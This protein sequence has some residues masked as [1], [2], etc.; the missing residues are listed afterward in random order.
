M[1]C[2]GL[3]KEKSYF[4]SNIFS[5]NSIETSFTFNLIRKGSLGLAESYMRGEFETNN[6]SDLIELTEKNIKI[7]YKFSGLF[8]FTFI[9]YIKNVFI[10]N[11]KQKK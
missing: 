2:S 6:L 8:D 1:H 7:I 4:P 3:G 10:K 9:N 11:T 5:P